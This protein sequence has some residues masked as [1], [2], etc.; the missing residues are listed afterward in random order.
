MQIYKMT[1]TAS[2]LQWDTIKWA[3]AFR[4]IHF[5]TTP[6]CVCVCV[7]FLFGIFHRFILPQVAISNFDV[8]DDEVALLCM[9]QNIEV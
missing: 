1:R 6:V 4:P 8:Y 5:T 9:N 2:V 7:A 3:S